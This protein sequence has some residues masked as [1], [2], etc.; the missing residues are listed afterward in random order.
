M[1]FSRLISTSASEDRLE[2]LI[3]R[4]LAPGV[5]KAALDQRIWDLFGDEWDGGRDR[6]G[7][8]WKRLSVGERAGADLLVCHQPQELAALDQLHGT[9]VH[10]VGLGVQLIGRP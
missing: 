7:W 5:D 4:R 10:R 6:P 2:K 8:Q 3:E 1:P 9:T